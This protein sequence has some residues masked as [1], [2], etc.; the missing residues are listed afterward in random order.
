MSV[1]R[2]RMNMKRGYEITLAARMESHVRFIEKPRARRRMKDP[3]SNSANE[4]SADS[5][6]D[7]V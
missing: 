5:L 7:N 3:A 2:P 6:N 1:H 4:Y